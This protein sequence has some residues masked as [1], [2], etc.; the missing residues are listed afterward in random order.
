MAA[1]NGALTVGISGPRQNSVQETD[2]FYTGDNIHEI[3]YRVSEPGYY[4]ISVRW[5]DFH[6]PDSPF[7]CKVTY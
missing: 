6:I 2:V 4:I 3:L 1:G 7:V 5:S